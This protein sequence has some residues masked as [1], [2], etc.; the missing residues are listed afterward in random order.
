M[1]TCRGQ[2]MMLNVIHACSIG[3]R[4]LT[5]H[6]LIASLTLIFTPSMTGR[7]IN[8]N[9]NFTYRISYKVVFNNL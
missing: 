4:M 3:Y 7:L 6:D 8:F 9:F 2:E 5:E 1:T